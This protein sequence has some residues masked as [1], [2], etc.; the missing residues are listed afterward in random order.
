MKQFA[1]GDIGINCQWKVKGRNEEEIMREI[2]KHARDEHG[3][4][5]ITPDLL[6]QVQRAIHEVREP[7]EYQ[8][9]P[10]V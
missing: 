5:T 8:E 6:A 10:T 9:P 3:V 1:C 4:K 7:A 2:A